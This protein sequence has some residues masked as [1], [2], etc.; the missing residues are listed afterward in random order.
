MA[1][2]TCKLKQVKGKGVARLPLKD[3]VAYKGYAVSVGPDV[4]EVVE[5]FPSTD[6]ARRVSAR[7]KPC[8]EAS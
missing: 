8:V 4:W 2:K 7:V 5:V 1:Y 6:G 3:D